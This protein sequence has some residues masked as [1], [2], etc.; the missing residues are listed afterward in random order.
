MTRKDFQQE[1][2][3]LFPREIVVIGDFLEML[4][5][6][7]LRLL[8]LR[9]QAHSLSFNLAEES[10]ARVIV[11]AL[12]RHGRVAPRHRSEVSMDLPVDFQAEEC[13]KPE[14]CWMAAFL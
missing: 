10:L 14:D 8:C 11:A 1:S 9:F 12:S 5:W 13:L 4:G 6:L 2:L 7:L 3:Q